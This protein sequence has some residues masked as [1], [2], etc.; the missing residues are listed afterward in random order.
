MPSGKVV[1]LDNLKGPGKMKPANV[2]LQTEVESHQASIGALNSERTRQ[3]S[4]DV[5]G[6]GK[7]TP[8]VIG[9][10]KELGVTSSIGQPQTT[11]V[12][13]VDSTP[14]S[15]NIMTNADEPIATDASQPSLDNEV[16]VAKEVGPTSS[17]ISNPNDGASKW[18]AYAN[19]GSSFTVCTMSE[20]LIVLTL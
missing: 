10:R 3:A 2:D 11:P 13:L 18:Q 1:H 8:E 12:G 5:L 6:D 17:N 7:S 9:D 19:E 15:K 16:D 20:L 4:I 14:S